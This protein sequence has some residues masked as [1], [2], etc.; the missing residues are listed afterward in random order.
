MP[1]HDLFVS[2][3]LAATWYLWLTLGASAALPER[4]RARGDVV[5]SKR[6]VLVP[7]RSLTGASPR[8]NGKHYARTCEDWLAKQDAGNKGGKS[9]AALRKDAERKGNDPLEG[10]KTFYR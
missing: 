5:V 8:L 4:R 3:A 2:I 1:S 6:V 10:E 9:I 7:Q